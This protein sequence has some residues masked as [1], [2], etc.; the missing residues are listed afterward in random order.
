M[1]IDEIWYGRGYE[2]VRLR[3]NKVLYLA[4][5]QPLHSKKM[6]F[7]VQDVM[8]SIVMSSHIYSRIMYLELHHLPPTWHKVL[9]NAK[10]KGKCFMKL[11][12]R[13]L[14]DN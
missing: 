10:K 5:V 9:L 7:I 14:K 3:Q 4:F 13:F 6:F 1:G 8:F 11:A 2:D 12:T